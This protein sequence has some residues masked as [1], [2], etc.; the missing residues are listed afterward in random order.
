M[1]ELRERTY[2]EPKEIGEIKDFLEEI[3]KVMVGPGS[4]AEK[5]QRAVATLPKLMIAADGFEKVSKEIKAQEIYEA[6]G[7]FVGRMTQIV[8]E[9]TSQPQDPSAE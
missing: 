3:T 4:G 5:M 6:M 7:A 8:I 9:A 2:K 1:V